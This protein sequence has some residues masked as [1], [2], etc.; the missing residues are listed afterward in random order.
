MQTGQKNC[1][2]EIRNVSKKYTLG[3]KSF[4]ALDHVDLAVRKG[5][6]I[7]IV[8]KSGSG[9]STLLNLLGGIDSPTEGSILINGEDISAMGEKKLSRFRGENIG[10]VFQFFQL[11]PTLTVLE[12]VIMPM[13][14]SRRIPS[15]EKKARARSLLT[16]VGMASHADKFPSALSG[17]EQQRVAIA[18]AL[19]NDPD[20]VFA[21]E[22]TG[23]LD[24]KTSDDIFALLK[25]L[26]DEGKNVIMVT[27]NNEL[28]ERCGRTIQIQDGIILRDQEKV[29]IAGGNP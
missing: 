23:N 2:I 20:I 9:K 27:H 12:N 15:A 22:P 10:F 6:Y 21:D 24:S 13:D 18:R 26:T 16:K 17:G 7:A 5:E 8:G 29:H 1:V 28:A 11:M 3:E 25:S 4:L 14:F 19:A